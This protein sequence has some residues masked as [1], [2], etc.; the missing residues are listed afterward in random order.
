MH[1]NNDPLGVR[2]AYP[3][4]GQM[5]R[6]GHLKSAG[7]PD[8]LSSS[9]RVAIVGTSLGSCREVI[10]VPVEK[11]ALRGKEATGALRV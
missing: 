4:P 10:V 9:G 5:R 1:A 2:S 8:R 3:F 11:I 7:L 6:E